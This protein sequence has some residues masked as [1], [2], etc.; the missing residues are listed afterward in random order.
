MMKNGIF[1]IVLL[2]NGVAFFCLFNPWIETW[3]SQALVLLVVEAAS[4]AVIGG[5]VFCYHFF[6]QKK[7]LRLSLKDTLETIMDFLAGWV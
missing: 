6:Y 2:I 1:A 3:R 4:A 7:P 5:P